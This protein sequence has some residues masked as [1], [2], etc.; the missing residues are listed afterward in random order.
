MKLRIPAGTP[1]GRT[2]RVRGRG[3]AKGNGEK[4]DL[5]ATIEVQVPPSLTDEARQALQTFADAAGQ[6]NPRAD[7][8]ASNR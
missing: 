8:L 7:L 1:N 4:G 2:F 6:A 3:V 5:L